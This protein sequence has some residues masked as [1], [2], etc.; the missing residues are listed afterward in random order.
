[1][2]TS[3]SNLLKIIEHKKRD[4]RWIPLI[5]S[6]LLLGAHKDYQ[7]V[8]CELGGGGGGIVEYMANMHKPIPYEIMLDRMHVDMCT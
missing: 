1:M 6:T 4:M 5:Q 8:E 2:E 3:F 7:S